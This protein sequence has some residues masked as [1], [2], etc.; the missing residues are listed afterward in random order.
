MLKKNDSNDNVLS[1]D[2]NVN[3]GNCER[4]KLM[5]ATSSE[6][7]KCFYCNSTEDEFHRAL[8]FQL[9]KKIKQYA[10]ILKDSKCW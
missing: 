5:R 3:L 1:V 7:S 8:N 2:D 9:E 4:R 10:T 6:A